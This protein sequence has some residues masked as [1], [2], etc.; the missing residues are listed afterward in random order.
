M[1]LLARRLLAFLL[2]IWLAVPAA[3][4]VS[5]SAAAQPAAGMGLGSQDGPAEIATDS[6]EAV[7]EAVSRLTDAEVRQMLLERLDAVA[8][9]R[10]ADAELGVGAV[11]TAAGESLVTSITGAVSRIGNIPAGVSQGFGRF[12]EPRGATG[13]LHLIAVLVLALAVGHLAERLIW[14]LTPAAAPLAADARTGMPSLGATLEFL[15]RRFVF[16]GLGL[17]AFIAAAWG[18]MATVHPPE[19]I[20]YLILTFFLF[21]PVLLSRIAVAIGRFLLAPQQPE[22]RLLRV[23]DAG[24]RLLTTAIAV[25]AAL[26]GLRM[27]ILSFMGGHGVDLASMRLGFWMGLVV[28]GW[29]IYTAWRGRAPLTAMLLPG[30]EAT[31]GERF[32]ARAYPAASIVMI[33]AIWALGEIFVAQQL[34]HLLD[35]R[36][37]LTLSLILS[38]PLADVAIRGLAAHYAPDIA[39]ETRPAW[40][41]L[42]ERTRRG[43]VRMG[44]VIVLVALIVALF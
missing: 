30:E 3:W 5:M 18:V 28:Y 36:L 6:P 16:E 34:W 1:S 20:S 14:W 23:D 4:L 44:R 31:S 13:T 38:A 25:F 2:G 8:A 21:G 26:V 12:Y 37:P 41:D 9:E 27:Y 15:V 39:G 24:A 43:Y 19:P 11:L 22:Y 17:A 33:A 42:A 7:R 32:M 35:G 29:I 10:A 40:R